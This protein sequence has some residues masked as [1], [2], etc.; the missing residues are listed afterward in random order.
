MFLFSILPEYFVDQTNHQELYLFEDPISE[1]E[2]Y[3]A[4]QPGQD[5]EALP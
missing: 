2:F 4:Y 3:L 5:R 1:T